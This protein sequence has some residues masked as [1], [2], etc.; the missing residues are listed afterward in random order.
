MNISRKKLLISLSLI[1]VSFLYLTINSKTDYSSFI[2][3]NNKTLADKVNTSEELMVYVG[4]ETCQECVQ[5]EPT[6]KEV[7]SDMD[8]QIYYY[9]TDHAKEDNEQ[10]MNDLIETLKIKVVPTIVNLKDGS[11]Q[12]KLVGKHS[13]SEIKQFFQE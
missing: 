10:L 8:K 6:L 2:E 4:R 11:I 7:L 5:F 12:D 3:L 9:N 1:L 13:K